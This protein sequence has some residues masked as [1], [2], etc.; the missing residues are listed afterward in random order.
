MHDTVTD[1]QPR[2]MVIHWAGRYDLFVWLLTLGKERQFRERLLEPA[3]LRP[4][5]SV[6]DVG[7]GTGSLALA[8][9]GRVGAAGAVQG[10]DPSPAMI[11]RSRHKAAKAGADVRFDTA[12]V[13]SLPFEDARFDVV[14]S[15]LM[16]HHIP[17]AERPAAIAEMRR[18]LKPGGRLLVVDFGGRENA[19]GILAHL[20]RN[21]QVKADAIVE[22][23]RDGGFAVADTGP[24]GVWN[25]CFVLGSRPAG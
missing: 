21:V 5:E 13:Q 10:I 24:I 6:L 9:K 12:F 3:H 8:A 18:V 11:G 7:C 16:L 2:G 15:T 17:R 22:V 14:L 19:H 25:L 1:A 23:V 4:G 20:H